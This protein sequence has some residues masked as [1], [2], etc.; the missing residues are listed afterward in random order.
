VDSSH[1][2]PVGSAEI[3]WKQCDAVFPAFSV[4]HGDLCECK[5]DVFDSQ[6]NAFHQPQPATITAGLP[7]VSVRCVDARKFPLPHPRDKTTGSFG[8]FLARWTQPAELMLEDFL[9]EKQ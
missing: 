5:I 7:S 8:G 3:H 2:C 6:T 1:R 9:V 4:A